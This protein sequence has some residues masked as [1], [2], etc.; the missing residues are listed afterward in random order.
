[1]ITRPNEGKMTL[2]MSRT[3]QSPK[4][5]VLLIDTKTYKEEKKDPTNKITEELNIVITEKEN[6]NK[7]DRKD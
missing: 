3:E 4:V 6:I 7:I 2:I 1:M 5:E